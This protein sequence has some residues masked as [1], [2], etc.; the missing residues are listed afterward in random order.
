MSGLEVLGGLEAPVF[1]IAAFSYQT[2]EDMAAVFAGRA[3]GNLY[4]RLSNPP[5]KG[6][7]IDGGVFSEVPVTISPDESI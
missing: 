5:L 3:P 2:A 6:F 7:V 1:Q 4:T